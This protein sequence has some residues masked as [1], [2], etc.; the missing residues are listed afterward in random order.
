MDPQSS[1]FVFVFNLFSAATLGLSPEMLQD[2]L[3]ARDAAHSDL[4]TVSLVAD[5]VPF[6]DFHAITVASYPSRFTA[7]IV[8]PTIDSSFALAVRTTMFHL[9][10][11]WGLQVF[12]SKENAE[13]VK[14]ALSDMLN[15]RFVLIKDPL[16]DITQYNKLLK[17]DAFWASLESAKVLLFQSDSIILK[18]GIDKYMEYDYAGAPWRT[19]D[20]TKIVELRSQGW[21]P[22]AVGNGGFSLRN[23]SLMQTV[24]RK[25]GARSPDTENEDIFFSQ[26]IQ[27]VPGARVSPE[28]LA[29]EFCKEEHIPT[30]ELSGNR[31]TSHFAL[32]A[33]WYYNGQ[34]RITELL[35][36]AVSPSF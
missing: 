17:S 31:V 27:R 35:L 36:S 22:I 25:E 21:L 26:H 7:V 13:F 30:L 6:H 9:G 15:V 29:Y 34:D 8:E 12:H 14:S 4:L 18:S 16:L 19:N 20:N 10:P 1:P 28:S 32:H 2:A 33:A 3:V 11:T 24:I 23:V 5:S